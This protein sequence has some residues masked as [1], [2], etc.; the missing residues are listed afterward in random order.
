MEKAPQTNKITTIKLLETTK[1]RL[2]HLKIHQRETYEE[3]LER[4]LEIINL[5]RNNPERAQSRL[6]R[7]DK[8]RRMLK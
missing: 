5:S 1:S 4:M 6:I 3:V 8:Q 2:N 7:I